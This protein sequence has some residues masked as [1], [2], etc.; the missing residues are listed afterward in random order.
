MLVF[1]ILRYTKEGLEARS[2][3]SRC[4]DQVLRERAVRPSPFRRKQNELAL[5]QLF[6]FY[7]I[8]IQLIVSNKKLTGRKPSL[9]EIM[10]ER[11]FCIQP[12]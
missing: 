11:G 4:E 9:H 2:T 1:F 7:G 5:C 3:P 12:S 10:A 8:Q 6:L